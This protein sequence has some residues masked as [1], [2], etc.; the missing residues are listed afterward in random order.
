MSSPANLGRALRYALRTRPLL[1]WSATVALAV[2]A[3]L[4][5]TNAIGRAESQLTQCR[6]AANPVAG[7]SNPEPAGDADGVA[8]GSSERA[9]SV[10]T[11]AGMSLAHGQSVELVSRTGP[12]APGRVLQSDE[13]FT[14]VALQRLAALELVDAGDPRSLL[15][16]LAP[17]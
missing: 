10:A 15:V 5:T 2:T 11:P 13:D 12:A 9:L 1:F 14:V 6:A 4:F 7:T 3:G 17:D 8:L 16:L